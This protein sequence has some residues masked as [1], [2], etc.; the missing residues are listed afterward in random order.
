MN[1]CVTI[2]FR[3]PGDTLGTT[4]RLWQKRFDWT[5]IP[6]EGATVMMHDEGGW[7]EK[8]ERVWWSAESGE[9]T[10][11]LEDCVDTF[12]EGLEE[13]LPALQWRRV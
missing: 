9:V 3:N 2:S 8:V 11:E 10:V 5:A 7:S 6:A 13:S 4:P 12:G 1:V